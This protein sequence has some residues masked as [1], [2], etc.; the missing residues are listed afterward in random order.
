MAF[1]KGDKVRVLI[2]NI[3]YPGTVSVRHRDDTY[4]VVLDAIHQLSDEDC[5]IDNVQE[6]EISA[7]EPPA[8]KNKEELEREADEKRK[9]AVDATN[10]KAAKDA[11]DAE[12]NLAATPLTGDEHAF[13]ARIRPL[14]NKGMGG[15]SPAEITRYSYLI[16]RE[17]VK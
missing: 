14:M 17:K 16:K 6:D 11:A 13:I 9:D 12:A 1:A 8:P 2:D 4:G 10:A 3:F 15:P 7:L 5:F